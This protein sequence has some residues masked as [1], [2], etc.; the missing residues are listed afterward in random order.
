[1]YI[2]QGVCIILFLVFVY[3]S[4]PENATFFTRITVRDDQIDEPRVVAH[5]SELVLLSSNFDLLHLD[6]TNQFN[7]FNVRN[8]NQP[9]RHKETDVPEARP[10]CRVVGF[11]VG[12]VLG[13][14][15]DTY[16]LSVLK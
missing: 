14:I 12:A 3:T 5:R 4:E 7:N 9:L 1:M 13:E 10:D 2:R 16:F 11:R 15:S 6:L 8:R